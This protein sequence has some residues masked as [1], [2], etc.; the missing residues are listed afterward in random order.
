MEEEDYSTVEISTFAGGTPKKEHI[1]K[2]DVAKEMAMLERN[3]KGKQVRRYFIELEKK[4]KTV[5]EIVAKQ[6]QDMM[7]F[8][9]QQT[10]Y[11]QKMLDKMDNIQMWQ[12]GDTVID[13][14]S[15]CVEDENEIV[16]RRKMLNQLVGRMAKACGWDKNFAL[17]R[18]YKALE[19]AL[20]ISL[21]DYREVHQAEN[22]NM[23]I[24]TLGVILEYDRL[25]KTEVRL[26]ANTISSMKC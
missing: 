23:N 15:D 3:E 26:C 18:L 22:G 11:N 6:L 19:N 7:Q 9:Q 20:D 16:R 12:N 14:V 5:Q 24:S 21:D 8:I 25:Y 1:I 4:Y 17:H 2:L 13:S 10:D